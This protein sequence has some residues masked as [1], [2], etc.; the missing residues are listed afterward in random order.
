MREFGKPDRPQKQKCADLIP[1]LRL[2]VYLNCSPIYVINRDDSEVDAMLA[3]F[4][5][6]RLPS[7]RPEMI[8]VKTV[9]QAESLPAPAYM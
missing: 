3:D 7:F 2:A 9:E 6:S 4:A 1:F 5:N 8:H